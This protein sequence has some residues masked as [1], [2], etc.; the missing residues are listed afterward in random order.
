MDDYKLH[1]LLTAIGAG[2]FRKAAQELSCT[3]SAVT[4][5]MNALENELGCKILER[6]H[7][8][9]RWTPAGEALLP[10]LLE[11]DAALSRLSE[12]ARQIAQGASSLRIGAFSSISGT[13]LPKLLQE[14]H[15]LHPD[16]SFDLRVGTDTLAE[17][18]LSGTIDLALGDAARCR[19]FRWESLM[20]DPYFAVLPQAMAPDAD[21]I[22]QEDLAARPFLMA[23]MNALEQYLSVKPKNQ[24]RVNCDDDSTLLS[25]A[26]Q[27]IGVTAM[28][29]LCLQSPPPEVKVLAL[30]PEVKRTLGVALPNSPTKEALRFVKFLRQ[31]FSREA[32]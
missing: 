11:A 3:Q 30:I 21:T 20:D 9:V 6:D 28:P 25:M 27:G 24:L 31:R 12:R 22:S 7:N 4:Q 10:L 19:A 32:P 26:A 1:V 5:A 17:W 18:L 13:W 16:V 29:R 8:G 2:S 15:A 14:Y 23:P